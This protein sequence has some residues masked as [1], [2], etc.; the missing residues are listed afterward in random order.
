[1]NKQTFQKLS[2][3]HFTHQ[4]WRNDLAMAIQELTFFEDIIGQTNPI[5]LCTSPSV[6]LFNDLISQIHHFR[7]I[8]PQIQQE[9]QQLE[10]ELATDVKKEH[11]IGSETKKDQAYLQEKMNDFDQSYRQF[12]QKIRDFFSTSV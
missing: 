6:P 7:R 8:I 11:H 4:L 5:G 1:M 3:Q 12:K 2:V 10:Q 9:L